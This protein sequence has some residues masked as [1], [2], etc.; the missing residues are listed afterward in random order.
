MF[1]VV[2]KALKKI[3]FGIFILTLT[4]SKSQSLSLPVWTKVFS[5]ITLK[6]QISIPMKFPDVAA[7]TWVFQAL[8][9]FQLFYLSP[10]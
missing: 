2:P 7:L 4:L 10:S 9:C 8:L 1:L 3:G 5:F 6:F